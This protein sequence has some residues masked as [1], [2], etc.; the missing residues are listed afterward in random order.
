V[1]HEDFSRQVDIK[2]SSDRSFG[3]VIATVFLVFTFWPLIH[4][5]PVRWWALAIVAVFVSLALL[6]TVALAPLNKCWTKLGMLLYRLLSPIVLGLLFYVTMTPIALLMR[7]LGKDPLRLRHDAGA[8]SY[9]IE[10][11]PPGPAP[12]SMKHQF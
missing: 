4:A 1:T 6:W 11:T 7:R 3:L 5:G 10:R 9:W 8:A 12:E 2:P